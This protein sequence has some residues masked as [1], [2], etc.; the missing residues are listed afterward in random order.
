MKGFTLGFVL[1][2]ALFSFQ[3]LAQDPGPEPPV[4]T[5]ETGTLVVTHSESGVR[6]QF[7]GCG[8][9]EEFTISGTEAAVNAVAGPMFGTEFSGT[10]ESQAVIP[11]A[12]IRLP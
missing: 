9:V 7:Y 2:A 6:L 1:A 12:E 8:E 3:G 11:R 4:E 10:G 5:V